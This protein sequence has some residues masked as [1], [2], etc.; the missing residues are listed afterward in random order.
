M[1]ASFGRLYAFYSHTVDATATPVGSTSHAQAAVF[2]VKASP[3]TK[4]L[5]HQITGSF[6]K[7][8]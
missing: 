3:T 2:S 5:T 4:T 8:L 7:Y 6:L 1:S